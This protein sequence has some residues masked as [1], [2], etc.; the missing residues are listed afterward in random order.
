MSAPPRRPAGARRDQTLTPRSFAG[1]NPVSE[2]AQLVGTRNVTLEWLNGSGRVDRYEVRW[3]P[4]DHAEL[5][6]LEGTDE[7]SA[8]G[9]A[10]GERARN[11]TAPPAL[12][13]GLAP[14]VG[15]TL[16]LAAHSYNLTSDLLTIHT[17]TRNYLEYR[18]L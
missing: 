13:A 1:P 2:V 16:T 8:R 6:G 12:L 10:G 18:Y 9:A 15:Y 5:A 7:D 4:T 3:W 11:L 14:G 17:R